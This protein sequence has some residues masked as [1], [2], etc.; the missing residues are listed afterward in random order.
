MIG[1]LERRG[2]VFCWV[3][4]GAG[5]VAG[6]VFLTLLKGGALEGDALGVGCDLAADLEASALTCVLSKDV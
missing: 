2:T 1:L 4:L 3:S 5:L 6:R